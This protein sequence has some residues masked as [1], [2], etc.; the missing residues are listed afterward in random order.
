MERTDPPHFCPL[1]WHFIACSRRRAHEQHD[2]RYLSGGRWAT[3]WELPP[4]FPGEGLGWCELEKGNESWQGTGE[5]LDFPVSHLGM[6]A[7]P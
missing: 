5:G 1:Q 7:G 6:F 2:Q 4:G 3:C